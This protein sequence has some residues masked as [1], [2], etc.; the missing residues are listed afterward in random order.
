MPPETV[1]TPLSGPRVPVRIPKQ[2]VWEMRL[3]P[4]A[5]RLL[6]APQTK[7]ID[8]EVGP[9]RIRLVTNDTHL[10]GCFRESF[11]SASGGG[12]PA[13]T[14]YAD[15]TLKDD[16]TL[17]GMLQIQSEEDMTAE[18][19]QYRREVGDPHYRLGLTDDAATDISSLPYIERVRKTLFRPLAF[20]YPADQSF[21]LLNTNDYGELCATGVFGTVEAILA[22]R[23]QIDSQRRILDPGKSWILLHGSAA[24]IPGRGVAVFL[25]PEGSGKRALAHGLFRWKETG[26]FIPFGATLVNL[27][28]RSAIFPQDKLLVRADLDRIAPEIAGKI[29][30]AI[31]ENPAG[32]RAR[33]LMD[34]TDLGG[35]AP[36]TGPALTDIVIVRRDYL[37]TRLVQ[38]ITF[39]EAMGMLTSP[40]NASVYDPDELDIEGHSVLLG[41]RSEPYFNPC[42]L[43]VDIDAAQGKFGGLD[44]KRIAAL[45][46]LSREGKV[47]I[48]LVNPRLPSPQIQFALR[49]FLAGEC[50]RVALLTAK[51]APDDLV[52]SLGLKKQSKPPEQGRRDVDRLGLFRERTEA[53]VVAFWKNGSISELFAFEKGREGPEQV[54]AC[55]RSAVDFFFKACDHLGVTD[56]FR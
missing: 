8:V 37:E 6:S 47:R 43:Q 53:E 15:T 16:T 22:G 35:N 44:R 27:G 13:A 38:E 18:I 4:C 40:L 50:D 28:E 41:D 39:K 10:A 11:P 21:L 25:G 12:E 45:L 36:A 56:L 52:W 48:L 1:A 9:L 5:Q 20:Y 55:S 2:A 32:R 14:I 46:H 49:K 26:P 51:E 24:A 54:M 23:I 33:A 3:R 7:R 19:A 42:I 31:V 29:A 30:A 34:L 17:R